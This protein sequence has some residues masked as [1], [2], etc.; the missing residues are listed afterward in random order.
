MSRFEDWPQRLAVCIDQHKDKPF[1]WGTHDCVTFAAACVEAI[2]GVNKLADIGVTW[3]T[4]LGAARAIKRLGFDNL[5]D[6]V[7]SVLPE[8][9]RGQRGDIVLC[10][11][12]D[13]GYCFLAVL[14]HDKAVSPSEAGLLHIPKSQIIKAYEVS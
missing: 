6:A 4:E 5:G 9:A 2:T 13:E 3:S 14:A 11:G 10:Q 8:K 12:Q 7:A 1:A